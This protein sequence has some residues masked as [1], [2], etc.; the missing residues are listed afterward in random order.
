MCLSTTLSADSSSHLQVPR[1]LLVQRLARRCMHV[2]LKPWSLALSHLTSQS[3]AHLPSAA[4]RQTTCLDCCLLVQ[5]EWRAH[6]PGTR[7]QHRS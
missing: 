3:A 1:H 2:Q 6:R 4:A 7:R 5:H